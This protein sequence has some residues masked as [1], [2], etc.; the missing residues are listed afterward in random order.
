LAGDAEHLLTLTR[1][2]RNSDVCIHYANSDDGGNTWE[3]LSRVSADSRFMPNSPQVNVD[4]SGG[5]H[6]AWNDGNVSTEGEIAETIYAGSSDGGRTWR[7]PVRLSADDGAHSAYPRFIFNDATGDLL[8]IA[9]RDARPGTDWDVWAA[10]ST[11]GGVIW[12]ETLVAGGP[13][14]QWDPQ[15]LVD[16]Y[17]VIHMG[18]MEYPSGMST[19]P[20]TPDV[21][22][23]TIRMTPVRGRGQHLDTADGL[24]GRAGTLSTPSVRRSERRVV[25]NVQG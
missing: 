20:T 22:Y 11:D 6:I 4:M 9:W 10:N 19:M 2:N 16:P 25:A 17:G 1:W 5:V 21:P 24:G 12:T 13:G 14:D 7:T 23:V 8:S 15:S 3:N 18:V